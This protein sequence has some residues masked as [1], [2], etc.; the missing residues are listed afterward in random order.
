ML[1]MHLYVS[2]FPQADRMRFL[3]QE[4]VVRFL[5]PVLGHNSGRQSTK[6][7][8]ATARV[9]EFAYLEARNGVGIQDKDAAIFNHLSATLGVAAEQWKKVCAAK[10]ATSPKL[11]Q[12]FETALR[13]FTEAAELHRCGDC[14]HDDLCEGIWLPH[15][16]RPTCQPRCLET[17]RR[18][19]QLAADFTADVY[20]RYVSALSHEI[21]IDIH[22]AGMSSKAA[23]VTGFTEFVR[24]QFRHGPAGSGRPA[25]VELDIPTEHLDPDRYFSIVYVI[26]HELAVHSVQE[27]RGS[28]AP[29]APKHRFAFPEGLIDRVIY[30]ELT[31]AIRNDERFLPVIPVRAINSIQDYHVNRRNEQERTATFWPTDVDRGRDAYHFLLK[32]GEF[33]TRITAEKLRKAGKVRQ[34]QR[35][36]RDWAHATALKLNLL[37][38]SEQQRQDIAERL[39][40]QW[41]F[42][43]D[44]FP[45]STEDWATPMGQLIAALNDFEADEDPDGRSLL[46][47]LET[48]GSE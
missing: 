14:P 34:S 38:L 16:T 2:A 35:A 30:E 18:L 47:L 13:E 9:L 3:A 28:A 26:A 24:P 46:A 44:D 37:P 27:L 40:E 42:V 11:A 6:D 8:K 31:D 21:E 25:W 45:N 1:R 43:E 12:K 20:Q 15:Q 7:L 4:M 23:R 17:L 48:L 36:G 5:E 22:F 39:A 29:A 19:A 41:N 10:G 33:V 32:V